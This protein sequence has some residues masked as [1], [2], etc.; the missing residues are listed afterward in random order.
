MYITGNFLVYD[1]DMIYI[2]IFIDTY[3]LC[4]DRLRLSFKV[5]F[6]RTIKTHRDITKFLLCDVSYYI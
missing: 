4:T 3:F 6:T 1:Y 2:Y 5:G